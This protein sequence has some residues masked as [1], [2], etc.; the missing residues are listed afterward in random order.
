M[1]TPTQVAKAVVKTT[2][3]VAK[4]VV[5]T[6]K[7]V[8]K[9]AHK[10]VETAVDMVEDVVAA[11]T[12]VNGNVGA[13]DR[14]VHLTHKKTW[15]LNIPKDKEDCPESSF[16]ECPDAQ[17]S[18]NVKADITME[19]DVRMDIDFGIKF[20]ANAIHGLIEL[21]NWVEQKSTFTSKTTIVADGSVTFNMCFFGDNCPTGCG[22]TSVLTHEPCNDNP[23]PNVPSL[24]IDI[25]LGPIGGFSFGFYKEIKMGVEFTLSAQF[26]GSKYVTMTK[27]IRSGARLQGGTIESYRQEKS[28]QQRNQ[29][30]AFAGQVQAEMKP[31][32]EF[33]LILQA[34]LDLDTEA[35]GLLVDW[36]NIPVHLTMGP[37]L[38]SAIRFD[39]PIT[40]TY[41]SEPFQP[42]DSTRMSNA[43]RTR[44]EC[45]IPHEIET[46]MRAKLTFMPLSFE[47]RPFFCA[48]GSVPRCK[49]EGGPD[50]ATPI[51]LITDP[52]D[53]D[54]SPDP[55]RV[56]VCT[57]FVYVRPR[58]SCMHLYILTCLSLCVLTHADT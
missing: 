20:R 10:V 13:R 38:K 37:I 14:K 46:S 30:I 27:H 19:Y 8:A 48:P 44:G 45:E 41:K 21:D 57:C 34:A 17:V 54:C 26:E 47:F 49:Y 5:K 53:P 32:F 18:L 23:I 3:Q 56:Y 1:P 2:R 39:M 16:G 9:V 4:V 33:A 43:L 11:M 24:G 6:T 31:Y 50:I 22:A 40:V 29:D 52:D 51:G 7:T 15:N 35:T 12:E 55:V 42:V 58:I 36:L 28:P 25:T